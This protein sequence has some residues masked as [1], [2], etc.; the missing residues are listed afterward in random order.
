VTRTIVRKSNL[1]CTLTQAIKQWEANVSSLSGEENF[2]K[3]PHFLKRVLMTFMPTDDWKILAFIHDETYGWGRNHV[4]ISKEEFVPGTGLT[5]TAIENGLARL[6]EARILIAC[7]PFPIGRPLKNSSNQGTWKVNCNLGEWSFAPFYTQMTMTQLCLYVN[8]VAQGNCQPPL[9]QEEN[10]LL[11]QSIQDKSSA[12]RDNQIKQE[13]LRTI[14]NWEEQLHFF[15]SLT[16]LLSGGFLKNRSSNSLNHLRYRYFGEET[17]S[18]SGTL[19][20]KPPE[21]QG[22]S[23]PG[24]IGMTKKMVALKKELTNIKRFTLVE[25]G[26]NTTCTTYDFKDTPTNTNL[27]GSNLKI[28]NNNLNLIM[29]DT[30]DDQ[31]D[32]NQEATATMTAIDSRAPAQGASALS[33]D[34]GEN[35]SQ[36]S[37][38]LA[39]CGENHALFS[40]WLEQ[41]RQGTTQIENDALCAT[42]LL[43]EINFSQ[44][45]PMETSVDAGVRAT[46]KSGLPKT[47]NTNTTQSG[48]KA[49]ESRP[50]RRRGKLATTPETTPETT[51]AP[52][53]PKRVTKAQKAAEKVSYDGQ[54]AKVWV[55]GLIT[56]CY[57]GYQPTNLFGAHVISLH[58]LRYQYP[59]DVV[60]EYHQ[61]KKRT[62]KYW[63]D[64]ALLPNFMGG[65]I[66]GWPGLDE[67]MKA[68]D[69]KH[70]EIVLQR[71]RGTIKD[72]TGNGT[73]PSDVNGNALVGGDF[74]ERTGR[75][76]EAPGTTGVDFIGPYIVGDEGERCYVTFLPD[77]DSRKPGGYIESRLNRECYYIKEIADQHRECIARGAE[78]VSSF[79]PFPAGKYD[80]ERKAYV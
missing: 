25:K 26:M 31:D 15:C 23:E 41:E 17:P 58:F 70:P 63:R 13:Y 3:E 62:D 76:G 22:D 9:N 27:L 48:T 56:R 78:W 77:P 64:K 38:C 57:Q 71:E 66:V 1:D 12:L 32:H 50:R 69:R 33:L 35:M 39:T 42:A 54:P 52:M 44:A 72:D 73:T 2:L 11:R 60:V 68:W 5:I 40:E 6:R 80:R 49:A 47:K 8:L 14:D 10:N 21:S 55:D 46:E 59:L 79:N 4:K 36:E 29:R 65:D 16:P 61:W 20:N 18:D 7:H 19:G 67:A 75:F 34:A 74:A 30:L 45:A 28:S 51:P 37:F 24:G 43:T 53:K